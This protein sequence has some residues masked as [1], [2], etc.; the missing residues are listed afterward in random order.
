MANVIGPYSPVRVRTDS[1]PAR[2]ATTPT[3]EAPLPGSSASS[4]ARPRNP[5]PGG[6]LPPQGPMLVGTKGEPIRGPSIAEATFAQYQVGPPQRPPIRHDN[7]FLQ[8]FGD[9]NDPN[10]V[11]PMSPSNEGLKKLDEWERKL[12]CAKVLRS[13]LKDGLEAYDHFLHGKGEDHTFSYEQFVRGD[14][15]G[16]TILANATKDIQRGAE[17][18]YRQLIAKDPSLAAKALTFQLTGSPITVGSSPQFPYPAT[19]NWQKAIGG[20]PI[21][22]S[23][24]VTVQPP[25]AGGKAEMAMQMTLHAEDR[26]N[27]NPGA[28]DL[29]TSAPDSDNGYFEA[30][31]LAHQFTNYSTLQ[32]DVRW[33]Q[34]EVQS[35]SSSAP[36]GDA[37]DR[38]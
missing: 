3:T 19:E 25:K 23:G 7:G 34:G 22:L 27:F 8:K 17:A 38:R 33:T 35:A 4:Y 9:P 18:Y 1:A 11:E 5:P 28:N 2:S 31:G 26:Y 12:L 36:T 30:T 29:V 37:V 20:H 32:R 21:W 6:L 15:S 16:T 14:F 10:P 24:T 13:D